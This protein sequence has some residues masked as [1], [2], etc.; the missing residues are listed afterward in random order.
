MSEQSSFDGAISR[1]PNIGSAADSDEAW[2]GSDTRVDRFS[3][4]PITAHIQT[5]WMARVA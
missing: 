2:R 1:S 5:V 4:D 3:A